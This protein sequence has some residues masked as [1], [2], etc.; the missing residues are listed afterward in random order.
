MERRAFVTGLAA[1]LARPL[2]GEAQQAAKLYR[3]G[4]LD[5]GEDRPAFMPFRTRLADLGWTIQFESRFA[6][7]EPER[8]PAL[9]AQLVRL[10]VDVL[11]TVGSST[12]RAQNGSRRSRFVS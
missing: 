4:I 12:F 8:L 5:P 11:F 6:D 10:N 9:A 2:A 1:L 7:G 3:I